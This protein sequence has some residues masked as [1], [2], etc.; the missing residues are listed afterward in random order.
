MLGN[1]LL[2]I[3]LHTAVDGGIDLQA[4]GVNVVGSSVS[5]VVLVAP[6]IDWVAFPSNR[7][8][9]EL[10]VLPGSIVAANRFLSHQDLTQVVAKIS[11]MPFLVAYAM[12]V[13]PKRTLSEFFPLLF[14][15]ESC[16]LHLHQ[17]RIATVYATFWTTNRIEIAGVLAH[18]YKQG[19]LASV[20]VRRILSKV[21][22]GSRLDAYSIVEEVEVV[23]VHAD[24]FLLR[25]EA[26][27]FERNHPF[28]RL[29]QE[30]LHCCGSLLR[31]ELLGKLLRDGTS[32]TSALL[33]EYASFHD[34][35]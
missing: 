17:N 3:F 6:T 27:Q 12:E 32:T 14:C 4:I 8:F 7:V 18:A 31:V 22:L 26:F 15:E 19:T 35:S 20:E 24:D 5:I 1:S 9:I 2:S 29:L 30:S 33:L 23:E 21:S 25:V 28:D 34:G 13:Q 10:L 11:G 16:L